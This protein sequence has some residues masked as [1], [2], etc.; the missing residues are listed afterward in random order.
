MRTRTALAAL[1]LCFVPAQ[2]AAA[3]DWEQ[4]EPSVSVNGHLKLQT[5][6]FVPLISDAFQPHENEA[7]VYSG[8]GSSLRRTDQTCDPVE[9]PN[10]P[11]YAVDHGQ[12]P[13]SL[14][15]G[16]GTLQ[17]EGDW[18]PSEA[19]ILHAIV[20]GVRSV[21]LEADEWAQPPRLLPDPAERRQYAMDWAH[22]NYYTELEIRELYI[23]TD[24]FELLSLRIGRQ[25][26]AWG[27]IGQYRLLDVVNPSNDTWHFGPLESFEDTRIPLWMVKALVDF[28]SI[29]HNLELIWRTRSPC[30]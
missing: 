27:E 14:S 17:L 22:E 24:A 30:P 2:A 26:V 19:V 15:M 6:V 11:C 5:G 9:R 29:E 25:Q 3:Q 16:R 28:S 8:A 7:Y 12:K 4:E 18:T 20:R 1:L 10:R 23:D 21:K 13:G